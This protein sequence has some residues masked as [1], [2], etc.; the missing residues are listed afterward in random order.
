M[1]GECYFEQLPLQQQHIF[2]LQSVRLT[3][4]ART[5]SEPLVVPNV[6]PLLKKCALYTPNAAKSV[7]AN[8]NAATIQCATTQQLFPSLDFLRNIWGRG[9]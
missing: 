2:L 6:A 8:S 7:A 1:C 4:N 9:K 3:T 5:E